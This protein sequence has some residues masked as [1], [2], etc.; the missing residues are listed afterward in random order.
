[1]RN[2]V[3]AALIAAP[4][5]LGSL[6]L[7]A[8]AASFT[9]N[10]KGMKFSPA[11]LNVAPGDTVTFVNQDSAPHTATA[12]DGAFDTGRLSRGESATVTVAAGGAHN[13]ICTVHPAMKG[14]VKA[15]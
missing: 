14:V 4:L 2:Y 8:A 9:V 6:T 13:Y 11:T 7:P 3:A 12:K 15:E 1:M 10:I 5:A